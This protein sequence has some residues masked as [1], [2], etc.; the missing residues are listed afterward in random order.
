MDDCFGWLII[1]DY[2]RFCLIWWWCWPCY[3][4]WCKLEWMAAHIPRFI[5]QWRWRRSGTKIIYHFTTAHVLFSH[6]S[7]SISLIK[8]T[9]LGESHSKESFLQHHLSSCRCKRSGNFVP[10]KW[11]RNATPEIRMSH[12]PDAAIWFCPFLSGWSNSNLLNLGA[13]STWANL[14]FLEHANKLKATSGLSFRE[15]V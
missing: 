12:W 2:T 4:W 10:Y 8:R 3:S 13:G 14:F 11:L 5:S 9:H 7:L 15:S 1:W 6:E